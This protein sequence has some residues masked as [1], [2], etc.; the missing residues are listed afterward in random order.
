MNQAAL[1][2][3][4]KFNDIFLSYGES[5]E[6]S[7]VLNKDTNLYNRRRD[8]INSVFASLFSSAYMHHFV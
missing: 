6:Y 5:D 1:C 8:K 4:Q 2:L 3:C 7:F